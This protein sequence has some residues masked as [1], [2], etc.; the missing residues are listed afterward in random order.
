M[1]T[2][3]DL[4]DR[5]ALVTGAT[6]G[7]GLETAVALGGAGAHVVMAGRSPQRLAAAREQVAARAPRATTEV[8]LV[9]LA[10]L[11]TVRAA[12]ALI[13]TRHERLDLLVNN[14]GVMQTPLRTTADG[15]ELQLGTNHVGHFALTGLLMDALLASPAARV[16]TVSSLLHRLGRIDLPDDARPADTLRR[17]Y[18]PTAAYARSKLA[19]LV[20][21]VELQRRLAA[22]GI[23]RITS[24][25]AHPGFAATNLQH[26]GPGM[27][28]SLVGRAY[29]RLL[30]A[31]SSVV[32]SSPEEG[33]RPQVHAATAPDVAGGTY[34]GP[35]GVGGLR[36]EVGEAS[37]ARTAH[38][39]LVGTRLW[40]ASV[41]L[42]DVAYLTD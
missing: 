34:W 25:A 4:T 18:T 26:T 6:S 36:G 38:D 31:A 5:V 20:F 32:A 12:A 17:A 23:T 19:N 16:V 7:L 41:S 24:V 35:D 15:I 11:A 1:T 21:A 30:G 2:T 37:M 27:R 28:E 33:A 40:G 3:P 8:V 22:A 9:D 10:D 14:A 29:A 39:P 13:V 42:S